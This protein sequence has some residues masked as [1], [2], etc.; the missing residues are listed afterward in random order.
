[1][2]KIPKFRIFK[3]MRFTLKLYLVNCVYASLLMV[4][5][6]DLVLIFYI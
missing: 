5:F 3:V 1:M 2:K 6:E 4:G